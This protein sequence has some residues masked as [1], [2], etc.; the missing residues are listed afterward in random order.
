MFS[1]YQKL[2]SCQR[3]HKERL[4]T[5]G[6]DLCAATFLVSRNCRVK[7]RDRNN[8]W[9]SREVMFKSGAFLPTS[10]QPGWYVEAIDASCSDL[11]YEA[12]NN[13]RNLVFLKSLDVSYCP[14]MDDW[15]L[16]R[17]SGEFQDSLEELDVSG[18]SR[19]GLSGLE[20]RFCPLFK[21]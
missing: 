2:V 12:F 5:L 1:E 11:V 18:C 8:S 4:L 7:F 19:V 14:Q 13:M 20:V 17:I 9:V 10:W 16:D 15:C 6:P 21:E 3:F